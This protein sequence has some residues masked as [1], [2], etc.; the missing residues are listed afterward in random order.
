MKVYF[1]R[2]HWLAAAC[3]LLLS[4]SVDA[5]ETSLTASDVLRHIDRVGPATA[6]TEYWN[7]VKARNILHGIG[8]AD[9]K[10]LEVYSRLRP[11]SDAGASEELDDAIFDEALPSAPFRVIALVQRTEG[12][13]AESICTFTFE[14]TCPPDGIWPYLDRLEHALGKAK[15]SREISM[16]N[17]CMKGIRAARIQIPKQRAIHY[18]RYGAE[19]PASVGPTPPATQA[20]AS[21]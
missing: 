9:P 5:S 12:W 6:L 10:W 21:Q 16:R 20:P 8:T 17:I 19:E 7:T 3:A 14:A 13:G 15:T 2:F 18:C 11:V 4:E 1:P